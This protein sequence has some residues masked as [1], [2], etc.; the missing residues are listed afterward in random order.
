MKFV[1]VEKDLTPLL[2]R[3]ADEKTNLVTVNYDKF[4]SVSGVDEGKHDIR[5]FLMCLVEILAPCL[6]LC[7]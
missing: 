5:I 4:E 3:K 7:D 6:A 1:I 2:S